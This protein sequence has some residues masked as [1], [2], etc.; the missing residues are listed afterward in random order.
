MSVIPPTTTAS[1]PTTPV[2]PGKR[3]FATRYRL[4][5]SRWN[6]EWWSVAMGGPIGN[7]INALIGDLAWVTPNRITLAGFVAKLAAVPAL[8]GGG[9]GALIAAAILLQVSVICDCMDGS[10]ARYRKRPSALGAYLDKVTDAIGYTAVFG[11]FGWRVHHDTGDATAL[12]LAFAIPATLLI[13]GYVYWV[14]AALEKQAGADASTG[15]DK[16]TDFSTATLGE[17]ASMYVRSMP[18]VIQFAESDLFFWLGLA[19]VLG[20]P[21]MQRALYLLGFATGCWFIGIL[22]RRTLRVLE[23]D[24]RKTKP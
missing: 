1:A 16:R 6:E 19:L 5:R 8:V 22:V 24:R 7:V 2:A 10:L 23:L 17:R 21:W 11:A 9:P 12:V 20:E 3:T 13:R 14:V 15:I 4:M 18:R